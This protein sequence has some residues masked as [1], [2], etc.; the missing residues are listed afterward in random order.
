MVRRE[1]NPSLLLKNQ[2]FFYRFRT[3][4]G[5]PMTMHMLCKFCFISPISGIDI[6]LEF[7]FFSITSSILRLP[8]SIPYWTSRNQRL[9]FFLELETTD[10]VRTP[11]TRH[12]YQV[13][14]FLM[15]SSFHFSHDPSSH[16][17][18][19]WSHIV[20][21]RKYLNSLITISTGQNEWSDPICGKK[22]I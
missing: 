15:N 10:L 20:S 16:Q 19:K 13:L 18:K 3:F 21:S 17:K 5:I 22:C 14:I 11:P 6:I 1:E 8:V 7:R 4:T 9:P 12:R 2:L